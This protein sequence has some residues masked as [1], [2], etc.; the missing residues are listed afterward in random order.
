MGADRKLVR[1]DRVVE[2]FMELNKSP[3]VRVTELGNSTE[4][5]PF[6]VAFITS[7]EN[8]GRL[9]EIREMSWRLS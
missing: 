6:I 4:G 3:M 7:E 8:M 2:Y 5:N 9:E 1:W